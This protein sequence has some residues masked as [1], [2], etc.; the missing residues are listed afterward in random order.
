MSV[1][2]VSGSMTPDFII[3]NNLG[4]LQFLHAF[5]QL[6]QDLQAGNI[7]AAQQDFSTVS[8]DMANHWRLH[9]SGGGQPSGPIAQELHQLGEALQSGDLSTAQQAY[10]TLQQ[11][12]A[13]IL[14]NQ[15]ATPD[16]S[17]SAPS[18]SSGVSVIA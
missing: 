1:S 3:D 4:K 14:G 15:G 13:K 17:A 2:A 7:S 18:G 10:S 9:H 11:D 8:Q 12:L 5:N 6:G 16:Q